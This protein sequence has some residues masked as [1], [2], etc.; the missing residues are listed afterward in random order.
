MKLILD[1]WSQAITK[2]IAHI[3]EATQ[4]WKMPIG[5]RNEGFLGSS[6]FLRTISGLWSRLQTAKR[7]ER[8]WVWSCDERLCGKDGHA[9]SKG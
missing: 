8:D 6:E 1:G 7:E 9:V 4:A 5:G 2:S 3:G